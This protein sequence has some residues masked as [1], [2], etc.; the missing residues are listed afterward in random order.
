MDPVSYV[1][2]LSVACKYC[3]AAVGEKCSLSGGR[4]HPSRIEQAALMLGFSEAEAAEIVRREL[5][6]MVLRYRKAT[7]ASSLDAQNL[8]FGEAPTVDAQKENS[9]ETP[10]EEL[11][12][13]PSE[14]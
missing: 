10:E 8:N 5:M 2:H 9:G 1:N 12:N 13:T 11:A 3:H 4:A 7:G 6:S 14:V